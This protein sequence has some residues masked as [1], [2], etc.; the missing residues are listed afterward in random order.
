MT[1][2]Y[3]TWNVAIWGPEPISK[4]APGAAPA[5]EGGADQNGKT[6]HSAAEHEE[7]H[8]FTAFALE[9]EDGSVEKTEDTEGVAFKKAA[10]GEVKNAERLEDPERHHGNGER[11]DQADHKGGHRYFVA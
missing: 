3:M 7:D 11:L 6:G 10:G 9:D 5:N 1:T 8:R 2:E 4:L